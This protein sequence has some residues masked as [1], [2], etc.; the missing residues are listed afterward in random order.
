MPFRSLAE[1]ER[2]IGLDD[3]GQK[4]ASA[5]ESRRLPK[6][7]LLEAVSRAT[8]VT[9]EELI[10]ACAEDAGYGHLLPYPLDEEAVSMLRRIL[11]ASPKVR[12][13][14][15]ALVDVLTTPS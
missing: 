10:V 14:V 12:R 9:V 4:L 1:L 5:A 15:A 13:L 3:L 7:E 8:G 11:A 6:F 2:T